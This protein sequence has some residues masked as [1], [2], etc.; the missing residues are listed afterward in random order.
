VSQLRS[1]L[2][3]YKVTGDWRKLHEEEL[4]DLHSS[5]NNIR[6][7]KS[8]TMRWAGNLAWMW[9]EDATQDFVGKPE[10]NRPLG[11]SRSRWKGNIKINLQAV[12]WG[13]WIGLT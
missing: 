9:T 2:K 6:V 3:R 10:A 7:I 5:L 12:R 4:T 11:R 1:G 13:T 8:K